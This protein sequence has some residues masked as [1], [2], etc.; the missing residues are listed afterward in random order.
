M[1]VVI[2]ALCAA[3][4]IA[5]MGFFAGRASVRPG[6][7]AL[8]SDR[9]SVKT[10]KSSRVRLHTSDKI[11]GSSRP[12]ASA[13][14]VDDRSF[15]DLVALFNRAALCK[16]SN[17]LGIG[18]HEFEDLTRNISNESWIELARLFGEANPDPGQHRLLLEAWAVHDPDALSQFL[19]SD[20]HPRSYD[21]MVATGLLMKQYARTSPERALELF[22]R[23]DRVTPVDQTDRRGVATRMI[24]QLFSIIAIRDPQ[25]A[26]SL[27]STLGDQEKDWALG[28][29]V[30]MAELRQMEPLAAELRSPRDATPEWAMNLYERWATLDL[31]DARASAES[32]PRG[33][34]RSMALQAVVG[35]WMDAEP[36]PTAAN[37]F[38]EQSGT[39]NAPGVDTVIAKWSRK[40]RDAAGQWL[41]EQ[42]GEASGPYFDK[43]LAIYAANAGSDDVLAAMRWIDLVEDAGQ[44]E[45]AR[46]QILERAMRH[47]LPG[48]KEAGEKYSSNGH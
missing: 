34:I 13:L 42:V 26:L 24:Q 9:E 30:K 37:W 18:T 15:Q 33:E 5:L 31:S 27:A 10:A 19:E 40:D 16:R 17:G 1:R 2:Q 3:V 7:D 11:S 36:G 25:Q 28:S 45:A 35:K 43:A 32:F 41:G 12:V 23:W 39:A 20:L 44:R 48:A 6:N 38:V 29:I 8:S 46:T 22:E 21:G 4:L 47:Q 14:E